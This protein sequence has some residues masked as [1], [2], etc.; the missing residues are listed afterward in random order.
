MYYLLVIIRRP[1]MKLAQGAVMNTPGDIKYWRSWA[2]RQIQAGMAV[3]AAVYFG[4]AA[5]RALAKICSIR[6]C[7]L[8]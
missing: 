3:V 7:S 1:N 4:M 2:G 5:D 8:V 6:Q